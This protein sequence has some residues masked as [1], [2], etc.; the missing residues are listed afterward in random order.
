MKHE[1]WQLR[2]GLVAVL[3]VV[4]SLVGVATAG[5]ATTTT[6]Q[7]TFSGPITYANCPGAPTEEVVTSGTWSVAVHGLTDAT[8]AFNIFTQEGASKRTHHVA[9]GGVVPQIERN[10]YAFN[11]LFYAGPNPVHVY[12]ANDGSFTYTVGPP[13]IAFGLDCPVGIVTYGGTLK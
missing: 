9:Y 4:M 11:I 8:V 3:A 12:L 13:Y 10:G 2:A 6:Y 7:G 1:K 5:G